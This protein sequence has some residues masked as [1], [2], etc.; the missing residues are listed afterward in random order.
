MGLKPRYVLSMGVGLSLG[1][2]LSITSLKMLT[3]CD[4]SSTYLLNPFAPIPSPENNDNLIKVPDVNIHGHRSI[5][6]PSE[7]TLVDYASKEYEPR[8]L[9]NPDVKINSSSNSNLQNS[10][11]K[12]V[13]PR[14]VADELGIREKVLVSVLTESKNLNTFA[15]FINQTLG[16]HVD[17]ILFFIHDKPETIPHGMEVLSIEDSKQRL[18][19]FYVLNYLAKKKLNSYDWFFL[20]PDNTFIRGYKVKM[21]VVCFSKLKNKILQFSSTNF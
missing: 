7:S 12:L 17:Q 4:S 18:K 20:V 9:P 3:I 19:P 11:K 13:R 15:I 8:I 5:R 16:D 1:F 21:F 10:S 2:L 6:S 14:Y